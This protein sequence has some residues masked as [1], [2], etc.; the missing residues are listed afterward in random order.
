MKKVIVYSSLAIATIASIGLFYKE[1]NNNNYSCNANNFESNIIKDNDDNSMPKVKWAKKYDQLTKPENNST[2]KV[3]DNKSKKIVSNKRKV[4]TTLPPEIQ[5]LENDVNDILDE[6]A[7][8]YIASNKVF[9]K[10]DQEAEE[11]D[12]KI[13]ETDELLAQLDSQGLINKEELDKEAKEMITPASVEE[14]EPEVK[15]IFIKAKDTSL[16]LSKGLERL[17]IIEKGE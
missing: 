16:E 3:E 4:D 9:D 14:I 8:L 5:S 11:I 17:K 10:A 13:Q 1:L 7:E 2:L 12:S 6:T 15:D